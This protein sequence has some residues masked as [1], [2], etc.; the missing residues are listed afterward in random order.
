MTS[1]ETRKTFVPSPAK[2]MAVFP[3]GSSKTDERHATF[4]LGRRTAPGTHPAKHCTFSLVRLST[5]RDDSVGFV[6]PTSSVLFNREAR[7]AYA[8]ELRV[9]VIDEA[10]LCGLGERVR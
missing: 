3:S 5:P 10:R 4:V 9:R 6:E 7:A 2:K 1:A 8:E